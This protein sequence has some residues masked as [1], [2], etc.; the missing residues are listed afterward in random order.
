MII[1]GTVVRQIVVAVLLALTDKIA[2]RISTHHNLR[3]DFFEEEQYGH[4]CRMNE[5]T[6]TNH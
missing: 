2:L 5:Y 6:A 1:V 4:F 3:T